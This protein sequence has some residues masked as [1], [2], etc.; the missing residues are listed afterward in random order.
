MQIVAEYQGRW[1][2]RVLTLL[3][4]IAPN[5]TCWIRPAAGQG[6]KR[7]QWEQVVTREATR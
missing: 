4:G 1:G 3:V 2:A 7:R 6:L 5:G